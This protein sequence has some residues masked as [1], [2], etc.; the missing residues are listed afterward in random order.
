MHAS[1]P[2]DIV[3]LEDALEAADRDARAIV[4]GLTEEQGASARRTRLVE[5]RRMP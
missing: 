1:R 5:R 3:A 4:A 2:A